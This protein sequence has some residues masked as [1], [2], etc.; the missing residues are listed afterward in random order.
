MEA[1]SGVLFIRKPDGKATGDAF[2]RLAEEADV[3]KALLKHKVS[4]SRNLS[5]SDKTFPDKIFIL[6]LWTTL[7]PKST[8]EKVSDFLLKMIFYSCVNPKATEEVPV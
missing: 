3:E 1:E 6:N 8:S 2:V 7:H 5:V 4:Q